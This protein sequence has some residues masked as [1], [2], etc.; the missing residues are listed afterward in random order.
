MVSFFLLLSEAGGDFS[1]RLTVRICSSSLTEISPHC[2]RPF[3]TGSPGVLNYH[4]HPRWS[5]TDS[6]CATQVFLPHLWVSPPINHDSLHS[7]VCLYN[8]GGSG[9]PCVLSSLIDPRRS[10]DFSVFQLFFL[11]S[12]YLSSLCLTVEGIPNHYANLYNLTQEN[13]ESFILKTSG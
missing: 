9:L 11:N 7:P 3:M 4:S 8:L 1:L 12:L 6:S 10:V 5:F 2:V 13:G